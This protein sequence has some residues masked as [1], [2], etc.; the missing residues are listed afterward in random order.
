MPIAPFFL[1]W[2]APPALA[3]GSKPKHSEI[4]RILRVV[5]DGSGLGDMICALLPGEQIEPNRS[6]GVIEGAAPLLR[7]SAHTNN[8]PFR[9]SDAIVV[10]KAVQVFDL[11]A[12]WLLSAWTACVPDIV[13]RP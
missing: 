12:P 3:C 13:S 9:T 2:A 11:P 4:V 8:R 10:R 7:V 5:P 1:R 6:H